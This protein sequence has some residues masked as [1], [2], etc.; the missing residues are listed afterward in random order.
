MENNEDL[1]DIKVENKEGFWMFKKLQKII[2]NLWFFVF[3]IVFIFKT[4]I[5]L[6]AFYPH[7]I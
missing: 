4:S 2:P 3:K 6:I 5:F 7:P 1:L